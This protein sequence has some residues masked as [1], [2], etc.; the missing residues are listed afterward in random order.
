MLHYP[1]GSGSQTPVSA[2]GMASDPMAQ[3][4]AAANFLIDQDPTEFRYADIKSFPARIRAVLRTL[5]TFCETVEALQAPIQPHDADLVAAL[6]IFVSQLCKENSV[7][8]TRA[9]NMVKAL[10]HIGWDPGSTYDEGDLA[11]YETLASNFPPHFAADGTK[12][13]NLIYRKNR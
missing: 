5:E 11:I 13:W 1:G 3:L 4:E 7:D 12:I 9:S 6:Q 8:I 10:Q 2:N